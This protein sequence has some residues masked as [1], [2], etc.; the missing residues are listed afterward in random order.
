MATLKPR[1]RTSGTTSF[2]VLAAQRLW[3]VDGAPGPVILESP[4]ALDTLV[5]YH[6]TTGPRYTRVATST[7]KPMASTGIG[8]NWTLLSFVTVKLEFPNGAF[9]VK[10]LRLFGFAMFNATPEEQQI[11]AEAIN[12]L[13]AR[14]GWHPQIGRT[15]PLSETAAA[16]RLQEA[17]TLQK[18]GTLSGKIVLVP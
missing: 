4:H 16:H 9:Y 13:F 2:E 5:M 3:V 1:K 14:G 11:C 6:F 12:A 7:S 15:L 10:D 18:Q 17:N 8:R